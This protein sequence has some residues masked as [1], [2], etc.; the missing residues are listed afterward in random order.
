MGKPG[1][2]TKAEAEAKAKAKAEAEK[3]KNIENE[4]TGKNPDALP[5]EVIPMVQC[6]VLAG[7]VCVNRGG[8]QFVKKGE[9]VKLDK[10]DADN[11]VN[12][13]IVEIV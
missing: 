6:R 9:F 3:N 10:K 5:V 13:G 12:A 2:P 1:R 11:L 8:L 7:Q 4:K